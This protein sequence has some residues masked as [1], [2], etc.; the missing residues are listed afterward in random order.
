MTKFFV[1]VACV[2][3]VEDRGRVDVLDHDSLW[4]G[5]ESEFLSMKTGLHV[6]GPFRV[7]QDVMM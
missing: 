6:N 1:D 4:G 3:F 5:E 2:E 7:V